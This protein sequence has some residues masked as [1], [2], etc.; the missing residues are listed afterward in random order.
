MTNIRPTDIRRMQRK[1]TEVIKRHDRQ[2]LR[3]TL[4]P[5]KGDSF[6]IVTMP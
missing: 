5:S 1:H 6:P 4:P 3:M 2:Y